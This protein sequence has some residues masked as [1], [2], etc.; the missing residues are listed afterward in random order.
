MRQR[1]VVIHDELICDAKTP[2]N[3]L[4]FVIIGT[5]LNHKHILECSLLHGACVCHGNGG[6]QAKDGVTMVVFNTTISLAYERRR[7]EHVILFKGVSF[8][9]FLNKG[10]CNTRIIYI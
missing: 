1:E 2:L 8:Y 9:S 4:S 6:S 3:V 7:N 10:V 5:R